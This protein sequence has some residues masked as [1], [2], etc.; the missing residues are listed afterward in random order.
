MSTADRDEATASLEHQIAML[1]RRVR[2][3]TAERAALVHPDLHPTSYSLLFTLV[4]FGPRRARELAE[5]FA[6]DKGA[7]SRVVHQLVELGFVERT[8]DPDDGRAQILAATPAALTRFEE[9]RAGRR[10]HLDQRLS[11]WG[12]DEI[13]ELAAGLAR[14]ND[15][16][17]E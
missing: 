6:L 16:S 17:P 13:A 1:L 8:P 7:V 14:F 10:K 5:M 3:G 2:R 12:T 4:D 9:A 11:D 15:V